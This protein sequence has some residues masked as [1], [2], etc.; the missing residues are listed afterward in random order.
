M[1]N[2]LKAK[3]MVMGGILL[4]G[5]LLSSNTEAAETFMD[6]RTDYWAESAIEWGSQ[7]ELITGYDD[8][9]FRPSEN[10]T[11]AQFAKVILAYY[12]AD[13]GS[14][15]EASGGHWADGIYETLENYAVPLQGYENNTVR[16]EPATRGTIAQVIAYLNGDSPKEDAAI[17][18]L[19]EEGLTTG[20][21]EGATKQEQYA[22]EL[23]LSR[24]EAVTFLHRVDKQGRNYVDVDGLRY[25]EAYN[26]M[27]RLNDNLTVDDKPWKNE[28]DHTGE[29]DAI[30]SSKDNKAEEQT[31]EQLSS[32]EAELARL[33]NDYRTSS[34]LDPMPVSKSLTKVAR[35]HVEDSN[36]YVPEDGT[37][38]RGMECN[39]HSWSDNGSWSPVCYTGDH[40]YSER[41]WEKP[42][43][44]TEYTGNG[45]EIS[46]MNTLGPKPAQ[47]LEAW[48]NSPG[49]NTVIIGEDS[50]SDLKVMG[51]GIKGNY[52][53]V[54][55]GKKEDPAGYYMEP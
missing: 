9:T 13:L 11:E 24:A 51:V 12:G 43:E 53:H 8:H 1:M 16:N 30:G 45:F 2:K 7:E 37:D 42:K 22:P 25:E 14:A 33:I 49:H 28:M 52:A 6:V 23:G 40:K 26:E 4:T 55:F 48:K 27:Q 18:Y 44:L 31:N 5:L 15:D 41:M 35:T 47:T 36:Q 54:W 34:G 10:L 21:V 50:W 32:K 38:D 20:K 17:D 19:F 46:Y 39:L 29:A 3:R